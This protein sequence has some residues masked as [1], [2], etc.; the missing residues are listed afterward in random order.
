MR[1]QLAGIKNANSLALCPSGTPIQAT[2]GTSNG[3]AFCAYLTGGCYGVDIEY[4]CNDKPVNPERWRQIERIYHSALERPSRERGAFL[5]NECR[6]DEGLLREVQTLL[7]RAEDA[8]D[9]LDK[10]AAAV[11]A[12]VMSQPALLT[13]SRLGVYELQATIGA[14]GM[15]VVYRA[16]DTNLNRSVAIKVL[17]DEL[18]DPSARRRFQREAQ[19]ASSLNHPHILTVHDAGEFEGR[20]YLVTEFVDGGTLKDWRQAARRSW[21]QT[22]ELLVGVADGLAA[23][24]QA[25]I[26]HRDVKPANILITKSGYAKLADFG[27]AKLYEGSTRDATR[28]QTELTTRTG[29]VVGT[30]AYMSP[31]QTLGRAVDARSDI[32]SFG[33]VLYEVLA[34]R[35]PFAGASDLDVLHAVVHQPAEPLPQ[36]VPLPL[37]MVVE[38]ALEKDPADRF[39]SMRDMVVDLRRIVRQSAEAPAALAAMPRSRRALKWMAAA[40]LLIVGAVAAVLTGNWINRWAT[41]PFDSLA[42]LPFQNDTGD[43]SLDHL[44]EGI[45]ESLIN[46]FGQISA[47]KV[48]ARSATAGARNSDPSTVGKKLSVKA[49]LAGRMYRKGQSWAV[50]AELIDI[51]SNRHLWGGQYDGSLSEM[52]SL[53]GTMSRDVVDSLHLSLTASEKQRLAKRQTQSAEAYQ[54]YSLGHFYWNKRTQEGI[55]RAI[56]NYQQAIQKDPK[57][58]LAWAELANCYTLQAGPKPPSEMYPK[59][60]EAVTRALEIDDMLGE[61]HAVL[62]FIKLHYEWDWPG[63]EQEYKRAI[64][65][66]PSYATAY[67]MYARYLGVMGRFDEAIAATRHAQELDPTSVSISVAVGFQLYLARRYDEAIQQYMRTLEMDRNFASAHVNLGQSLIQKGRYPEAIAELKAGLT[68]TD[69]GTTIELLRAHVLAGQRDEGLRLFKQVR[70]LS[71][72]RYVSPYYLAVADL[73]LGNRDQALDLLEKGYQERS[74]PMIFLNVDPRFDRLRSVP[75]FQDLL[76]RLHLTNP[77]PSRSK[78]S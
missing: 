20:Q 11:S 12:Q 61:A 49:V 31:E 5:E 58:A 3:E 60:L 24:H 40:A 69:A 62:G 68:E 10:P 28:L 64:A 67:S 77:P 13:G 52:S 36:D 72:K 25:G 23:A 70:E 26:L 44:S 17:S 35:R 19:M 32:F 7:S 43:S 27:L 1:F 50:S 45:T 54:L 73:S 15:G 75:R 55:A 66:N 21:R 65:L 18:A 42:V 78:A 9:F 4:R 16:L 30:V 71:A 76:K 6:G 47:L 2:D 29:V 33:V 34:G 38:K 37:R 59:A 39:Q 48:M 63:T 46:T 8:E 41:A 51:R 56:D 22:V 57:F 14:G 74:W 53:P